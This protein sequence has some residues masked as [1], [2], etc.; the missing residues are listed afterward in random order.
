[1]ADEEGPQAPAPQGAR[2][3][4][5]P[6]NPSPPQNPQIPIVPNASQHQKH[7]IY[8]HHTYHP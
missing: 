3:P 5:A 6:Q 8:L 4:P 1:M 7:Y 2:D